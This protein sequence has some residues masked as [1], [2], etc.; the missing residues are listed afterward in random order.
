MLLTPCDLWTV[1]CQAPLSMGFSRQECWRGLPFPSPGDLPGRRD[2]I[3][4]SCISLLVGGF[5][6]PGPPGKPNTISAASYGAL[7][8]L[9]LGVTNHRRY[10]NRNVLFRGSGG[11]KAEAGVAAELGLSRGL[12][13]SPSLW[14]FLL[15][16]HTP[17]IPAFL[18]HSL[19]RGGRFSLCLRAA[20]WTF[21]KLRTQSR[22]SLATFFHPPGQA[23]VMRRGPSLL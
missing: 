8:F 19:S 4:I 7:E 22:L 16:R 17:P 14:C 18:S 23:K 13:R 6:T 12:G 2:Q 20:P 1:A 11:R 5:F 9:Q 3:P 21:L 15:S 10:S